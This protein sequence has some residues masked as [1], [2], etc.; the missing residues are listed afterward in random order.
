ML[1]LTS[2]SPETHAFTCGVPPDDFSCLFPTRLGSWGSGT[3]SRLWSDIWIVAPEGHSH[4]GLWFSLGEHVPPPSQ[5]GSE[6]GVPLIPHFPT[7]S[8]LTGPPPCRVTQTPVDT[9]QGHVSLARGEQSCSSAQSPDGVLS[10][11]RLFFPSPSGALWRR[12]EADKLCNRIPGC[13]E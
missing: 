11:A 8:L 1:E 4:S 13:P 10:L 2:V 7:T 3:T 9:A 6:R 12:N 5:W